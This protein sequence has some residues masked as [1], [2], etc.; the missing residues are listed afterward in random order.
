MC[1]VKKLALGCVQFGCD[2]GITNNTG[3]VSFNAAK[4]CVEYAHQNGIDTI[5]TAVTYGDSEASLGK[6]GVKA[7]KVVS[8]ITV[9]KDLKG[10]PSGF[11]QRLVI[12]SLKTLRIE[13][14]HRIAFPQ[15]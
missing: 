10:D 11:A 2:Y 6:I 12:N 9:S 8:K 3:K 7:F 13:S 14:L 4:D 15:L 1:S 5:D